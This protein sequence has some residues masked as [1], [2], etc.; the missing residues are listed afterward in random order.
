MGLTLTGIKDNVIA[1]PPVTSNVQASV[2]TSMKGA[3]IASGVLHASILIASLIGIPFVVTKEPLIITPISV[4]LVDIAEVTQTTK[5]AP[6]K[7]DKPKPIEKPEPPKPVQAAP[8]VTSEAPPSIEELKKPEEIKKPEEPKKTVEPEPVLEAK[9]DTPKPKDKPK[10]K[11]KD[12]PKPQPK[13][14]AFDSLLKNLAPD[15]SEVK[16]QQDDKTLDDVIE[17]TAGGQIAT[18]A[19]QLTISELD[20]FKYQLEPCW[21]VPAGAKFAEDLAVEIRVS[22]APDGTVKSSSVLNKARY[23]RDS[24]FRAA[25]DSALRALRN[26]RCSPLKLPADK[27]EQWKSIVINFDPKEML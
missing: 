7:P 26:P 12:K 23:N 24:A 22:M 17:D 21:N 1:A 8:K 2:S 3:F 27:Y 9:K 5:V 15:A 6:P 13:Q 14:D 10:P 11:P 18:L 19:D 20:A 25:A 4:E 16:T